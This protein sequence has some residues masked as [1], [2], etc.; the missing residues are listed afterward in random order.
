MMSC[1]G[2]SSVSMRMLMRVSVSMGQNT[3]LRPA[4]FAC[5]IIRPRPRTTPRSHSLM[6]YSEFQNQMST[7]PMTTSVPMLN[8]NMCVLLTQATQSNSLAEVWS[9]KSQMA[10]MARPL[11][12]RFY[13]ELQ[14]FD[15][16][17][18]HRFTF[19]H[20]LIGH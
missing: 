16:H 11:S 19:R 20:G 5:G 2:T 17:Y 12:Y 10:M 13:I 6:M 4:P 15:F 18:A 7:K 9:L 3:R 1:G 14:A 8:S